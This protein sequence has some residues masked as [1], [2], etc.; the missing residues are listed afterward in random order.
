MTDLKETEFW[1]YRKKDHSLVGTLDVTDLEDEFDGVS[2]I[3]CSGKLTHCGRSDE[4]ERH[5]HG[6]YL[7]KYPGKVEHL[8]DF[9]TREEVTDAVKNHPDGECYLTTTPI[10]PYVE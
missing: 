1:V 6:W 7:L 5:F 10:L 3:V 2:F 4:V 8:G 9:Q